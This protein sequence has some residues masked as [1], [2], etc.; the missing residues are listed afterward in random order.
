M[1]A[2]QGASEG[3]GVVDRLAEGWT[4]EQSGNEPRLRAVGCEMIYAF[5]YRSQQAEQLRR[6]TNPQ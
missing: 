5:I 3:V 4:P 1:D 6:Y 2:P